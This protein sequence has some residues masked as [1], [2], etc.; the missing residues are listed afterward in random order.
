MKA[1]LNHLRSK[2]EMLQY[3]C[4][5]PKMTGI[6]SRPVLLVVT[7]HGGAFF[8][9]CIESIKPCISYFCSCIIS[10]N[11]S[12]PGED[13]QSAYQIALLL[14]TTIFATGKELSAVEHS[15][16]LQSQLHNLL[17]PLQHIFILCHDDL[18][19]YD[20]FRRLERNC[21][22]RADSSLA[23]GSYAVFHEAGD[24]SIRSAFHDETSPNPSANRV[25]W[26][27]SLGNK[28]STY[29]N[30]SGMRMQSQV[31]IDVI[32]YMARTHCKKGLRFEYICAAHYLIDELYCYFLPLVAIREHSASDGANKSDIQYHGGELRYVFW[33]FINCRSR[34]EISKL[35]FSEF[36]LHY[37]FENLSRLIQLKYS[38]KRGG[39]AAL[40][41]GELL[42]KISC[43]LRQLQ[44]KFS[45]FNS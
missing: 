14:N 7:Y 10:I 34:D 17:N 43:C 15:N 26:R 20:S 1:R 39:R 44:L 21:W 6:S 27:N 35:L 30:A 16:L 12:E 28:R 31:F 32:K 8:R 33:L 11:G 18:L 25:Q 37:L 29:T 45:N 38:G 2:S 36:G 24:L 19:L 22:L 3:A 13:L 40:A 41:I 23:L 42:Q 9:E 5:Y 4:A